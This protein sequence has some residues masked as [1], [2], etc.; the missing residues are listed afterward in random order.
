LALRGRSSPVVEVLPAF[1]RLGAS[2]FGGPV[3]HLGYFRTEFVVHRRWLSGTAYAAGGVLLA[4]LA[5]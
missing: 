5:R 4:V 2:G 1:S 3:A